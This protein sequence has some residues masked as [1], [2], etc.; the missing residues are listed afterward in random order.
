MWKV[1]RFGAEVSPDNRGRDL[2]RVEGGIPSPFSEEVVNHGADFYGRPVYTFRSLILYV[3][4]EI[5][6]MTIIKL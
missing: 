1:K 6:L 5:F 4:L 2:L 3:S